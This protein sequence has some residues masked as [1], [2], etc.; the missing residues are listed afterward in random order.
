MP[1][2]APANHT[3]RENQPLEKYARR[4]SPSIS[5]ETGTPNC[6]RVSSGPSEDSTPVPSTS[7]VGATA[8]FTPRSPTHAAYLPLTNV[9]PRPPATPDVGSA[10]TCG[11][12]IAN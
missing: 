7:S 4:P 8:I 3:P 9:V 1:T 10:T 5:S 12:L 2:P 6:V 11:T